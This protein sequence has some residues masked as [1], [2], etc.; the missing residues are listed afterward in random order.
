M[1]NRIKKSSY[2]IPAVGCIF[3]LALVTEA[4]GQKV[5]S[6][7]PIKTSAL[8]NVGWRDIKSTQEAPFDMSNKDN[9]TLNAN[10]CKKDLISVL[11][12]SYCAISDFNK[13]ANKKMMTFTL[14]VKLQKGTS[15][16]FQAKNDVFLELNGK[17]NKALP[18]GT[19]ILATGKTL[20]GEINIPLRKSLKGKRT[21]T[22]YVK[23]GD[24]LHRFEL[25]GR[26]NRSESKT[27]EL[28]LVPYSPFWVEPKKEA[29]KKETPKKNEEIKKV[30]VAIKKA[31]DV[32]KDIKEDLKA[33]LVTTIAELR[34]NNKLTENTQVDVNAE[35]MPEVKPDGFVEYNMKVR[36][37]VQVV[38]NYVKKL[39]IEQATEDWPAGKY[40]LKD[41]QAAL[42]TAG[43]IKSTVESKLEQYVVPGTEITVKIMG[44][45]DASPFKNAVPY[46]DAFGD[47]NDAE[48][49]ING[50]FGYVSINK[51]SG[52]K[53]NE[54]LAYL[55]TL[56]IKDFM[57]KH[58]GPFR[59]ANVHYEHFAEIANQAGAQYRRVAVEVTIHNAFQNQY[60]EIAA[61]KENVYERNSD[62]DSNIPVSPVKTNAIAVII[63][64][65]D[66]QVATGKQGTTKVGPVKYAVNDATTMRDYLTQTLGVNEKNIIFKTNADKNDFDDIFGIEGKDGEVAKL[67]ASTGAKEIYFF[68]SGHGYPFMGEPYLLGIHSNPKSCKEQATSL[69]SIYRTLGALPVDK[70]NVITDACFSGQEIS[71]EASA[72]E[73]VRRPKPDKLA[74]FVI[75]SA[76]AEDQY[77]NWYKDKKHG[78]FSYALFKAMQDKAKSDLNGDGILTFEELYKY[79]SDQQT[80]GVPYLVKELEGEQV[81]QN[82]VIQVSTRAN[83][84]FVKY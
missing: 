9:P 17:A 31:E 59:V 12:N 6:I 10:L 30:E 40:R 77:A 41:S 76:A 32:T 57:Q 43:I 48:C 33:L 56:D 52:I 28:A 80:F 78:V 66:Y 60:P 74:K 24:D 39:S 38:S 35:V 23:I 42:Q 64:N 58:I 4:Y 2:M 69:Q 71:M 7:N 54:Q 62:V 21:A 61:Y 82:P 18:S 55:R 49:F 3:M 19:L 75:L 84:T 81:R 15:V 51:Q 45:T 13:R 25:S 63:G 11:P 14:E 47:I 68:Y 73:F 26:L 83:D 79:L 22:L 36:Y 34:A 70:I 29:P 50:A 67:V 8:L 27:Q 65:T 16:N 72:T 37:D 1:S 44:G 20:K 5:S 46:D 53:T